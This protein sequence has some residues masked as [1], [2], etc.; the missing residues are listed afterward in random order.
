LDG[1]R[2]SGTMTFYPQGM[3]DTM[4]LRTGGLNEGVS[5]SVAVWGLQSTWA[6]QATGGIVYGNVTMPSN[7][8]QAMKMRL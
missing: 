3:L 5:V 1:G 7:S 6:S 8:T 4:E 2:N